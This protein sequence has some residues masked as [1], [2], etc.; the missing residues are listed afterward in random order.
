M[1]LEDDLKKYEERAAQRAESEKARDEF[2][3]LLDQLAK[4]MEVRACFVGARELGPQLEDSLGRLAEQ[5]SCPDQQPALS[6]EILNITGLLDRLVFLEAEMRRRDLTP[7]ERS[8][9]LHDIQD[10]CT[11]VM[12][13]IKITRTLLRMSEPN[14]D[15]SA[16]FGP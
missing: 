6:A 2:C 10:T 13:G 14:R 11:Q 3:A 5:L 16:R 9:I 7:R 12:R 1:K 15:R 4:F 8:E